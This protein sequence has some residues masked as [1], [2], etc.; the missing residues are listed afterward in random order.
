L[1]DHVGKIQKLLFNTTNSGSAYHPGNTGFPDVAAFLF[2][3]LEEN[4]TMSKITEE[5]K[6]FFID[7]MFAILGKNSDNSI[8]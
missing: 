2:C 1:A 6:S 5:N 8:S 3:A 4:K 7:N